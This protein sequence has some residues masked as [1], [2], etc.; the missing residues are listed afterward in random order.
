MGRKWVVG[1]VILAAA[2]GLAWATHEAFLRSIGH[3]LVYETPGL[4]KVDALVVLPGSVPDR[5]LGA[6]DLLACSRAESVFLVADQPRDTSGVLDQL[7]VHIP[8]DSEINREVLVRKGISEE[9]I[10]MVPGA[11]D[12]SRGDAEWLKSFLSRRPV[13]SIALVTCKYHSYRAY[14]LFKREFEKQNVAVYSAP[15]RHC[16]YD[17]DRWWTSRN[18]VKTVYYELAKLIAFRLGYD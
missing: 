10:I 6:Y 11:S 15:S 18:D 5:A 3:L 2:V 9:R 12:S 14:L 7:G 17:P 4:E 16:S 1:A 8:T 13:R